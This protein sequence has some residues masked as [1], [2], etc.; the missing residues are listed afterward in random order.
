MNIL[1]LYLLYNLSTFI[2]KY[3]WFFLYFAHITNYLY[4]LTQNILNSLSIYGLV[5]YQLKFSFLPDIFRY[6][7]LF[8]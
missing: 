6:P 5:K 8:A 1:S 4:F 2:L 7:Y 3:L